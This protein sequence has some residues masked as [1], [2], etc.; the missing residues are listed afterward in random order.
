M[1]TESTKPLDLYRVNLEFALRML[2]LGQ[3]GRQQ[4]CELE[5]QRI[6]RDLA[7]QNAIHEAATG[8]R[9][10]GELASNYQTILHDYTAATNTLWQQGLV[11]V[12][13]QQKACSDG[14][15]DALARWQAASVDAWRK[16]AA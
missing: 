10:W 9:D 5:M 12:V 14:V 11:S 6:K 16:G 15:R 2:S 3:E 13:R 1:A 8:S 4:A 7:A